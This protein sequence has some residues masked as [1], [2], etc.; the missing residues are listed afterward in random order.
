M[1]MCVKV[2]GHRR[3]CSQPVNLPVSDSI[4]R[5]DNNTFAKESEDRFNTL[6]TEFDEVSF[7][8]V[9]WLLTFV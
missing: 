6:I 2:L 9:F 5:R 4:S 7:I 8:S 3:R 1:C